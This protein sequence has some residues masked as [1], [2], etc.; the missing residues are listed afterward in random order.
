VGELFRYRGRAAAAEVLLGSFA[1][2]VRRQR[3][4][5]SELN[6]HFALFAH[7]RMDGSW[8]IW[9]DRLG[10][11]HVYMCNGLTSALGTFSPAVAELASGRVLDRTGLSAFFALGFFCA[12][13]TFYEDVKVLGPATRLVINREG[14]MLSKQ[15][16]WTWHHEPSNRSFNETVE[17]FASTIDA[18]VSDQ[19]KSGAL[20]LPI[21]SGLDSRTIAGALVSCTGGIDPEEVRNRLWSY[22][23]G[24]TDDSIETAAAARIATA[25]QFPFERFTVG[26]Y[27]FDRVDTILA[28]IEGFQGV[29]NTRQAA[30]SE[31][32]AAHGDYLLAAHWGDVWME[33]MGLAEAK[34]GIPED[35][36]VAHAFRRMLK[37]GGIELLAGASLETSGHEAALE[38]VREELRQYLPS[39]TEV[40]EPDFRVKALKTDQWS[41]RWTTASLRMFQPAAFPRLPF[42]DNRMVD[43]CCTIPASFLQGR[44]L[45]IEYLKRYHPDLA[46]ITWDRTDSSLFFQ[47]FYDSWLLPKRMYKKLRRV[48]T[49]KRHIGRNWEVQLLG[50]TGR[51]GI[52]RHLLGSGL[53]IHDVVPRAFTTDLVARTYSAPDA[54]NGYALNQLLTLSLWLEKYG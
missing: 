46:R 6:G 47:Q 16:Y 22:S 12:D 42:Y 15:R 34:P 4:I 48:I 40:P 37:P 31:S 14:K 19:I 10:T 20:V 30:I 3:A 23:Y 33:D 54:G 52:E 51:D 25:A 11:L 21:S 50:P 26:D 32:I 17:Q 36:I 35:Q 43:F 5:E 13:R 9:T 53:R 45:Q 49:G 8:T 38:I 7:D 28:S 27:L 39:S 1:G 18:I 41:H 24:F 29:A 44:R 2:D